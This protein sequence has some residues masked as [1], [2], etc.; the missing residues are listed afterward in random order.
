M[1]LLWKFSDKIAF[2]EGIH[3]YLFSD[4]SFFPL[5]DGQRISWRILTKEGIIQ[6]KATYRCD[7]WRYQLFNHL[8]PR[9]AQQ[10]RGNRFWKHLLI[11]NKAPF[12]K[13]NDLVHSHM[14]NVENHPTFKGFENNFPTPKVSRFTS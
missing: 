10:V 14:L 7:V 6:A 11:D 9:D 3:M 1:L 13:K 12:Q 5:V 8:F 2:A 4:L